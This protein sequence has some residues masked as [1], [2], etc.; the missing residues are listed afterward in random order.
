MAI[1]ISSSLNEPFWDMNPTERLRK[2]IDD[3]NWAERQR[4][5]EIDA[6]PFGNNGYTWDDF[7]AEDTEDEDR[8]K[9][10]YKDNNWKNKDK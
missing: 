2:Q 10:K 7:L 1:G 4:R 8:D 3:E 6:I 5:A 9:Q